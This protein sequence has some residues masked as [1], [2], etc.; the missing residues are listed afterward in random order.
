MNFCHYC[1]HWKPQ[2]LL[3]LQ[4]GLSFKSMH[5]FEMWIRSEKSRDL[6]LPWCWLVRVVGYTF[7][8]NI[9]TRSIR[10]KSPH[11]VTEYATPQI[12]DPTRSYSA[13]IHEAPELFLTIQLMMKWFQINT[14]FF[15]F[16]QN[17]TIIMNQALAKTA[18]CLRCNKLL[19][20]GV[21]SRL[22]WPI[23]NSDAEPSSK[24]NCNSSYVQSNK[25]VEWTVIEIQQPKC[26]VFIFRFTIRILYVVSFSEWRD[27]NLEWLARI[28]DFF[29]LL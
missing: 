19:L 7:R 14:C 22:T 24:I 12:L 18:C 4:L 5:M 11:E 10:F 2:V 16:L 20:S 9:S 13:I 3:C 8:I 26:A 6:I 21:N 23:T 1:S 17:S 28:S 15:L 25:S 27:W 29:P